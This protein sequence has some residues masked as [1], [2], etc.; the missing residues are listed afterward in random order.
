MWFLSQ[1]TVVMGW[2]P[3]HYSI[4]STTLSC[5]HQGCEH[6]KQQE[7]ADCVDEA[8]TLLTPGTSSLRQSVARFMLQGTAFPASTLWKTR[9]ISLRQSVSCVVSHYSHKTKKTHMHR[10]ALTI[11]CTIPPHTLT[12]KMTRM[13]TQSGGN[14]SIRRKRRSC[15]KESHPEKGASESRF[16]PTNTILTLVT[17]AFTTA[18]LSAHY[19]Q[20][21]LDTGPS[22]GCHL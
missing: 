5:S 2:R 21:D 4:L 19:R 15:K 20:Q 8:W 1:Q 16:E 12:H 22:M 3:E 14:W 9:Y 13:H 6:F 17:G 11:I 18:P 10:K 7:D